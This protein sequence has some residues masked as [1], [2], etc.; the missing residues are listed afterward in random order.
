[1]FRIQ[2]IHTYIHT[3]LARPHGAFQSQLNVQCFVDGFFADFLR[4]QNMVRV[5][6]GKII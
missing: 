1:M 3:L 5:I 2:Y 4:A 6:K